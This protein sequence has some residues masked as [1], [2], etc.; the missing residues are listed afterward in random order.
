VSA[1]GVDLRLREGGLRGHLNTVAG[2]IARIKQRSAVTAPGDW[3]V[4]RGL[5][6]SAQCS[7]G[8]VAR[9]RGDALSVFG[10]CHRTVMKTH[11]VE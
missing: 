9:C 3:T 4:P 7:D 1:L 8:V 5:P 10:S 2:T 11:I 6:P